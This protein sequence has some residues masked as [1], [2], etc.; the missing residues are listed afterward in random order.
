MGAVVLG[1]GGVMTAVMLSSGNKPATEKAAPSTAPTGPAQD[2][3]ALARAE[4]EKYFKS[5]V[6][7]TNPAPAAAPVTRTVAP[8][9]P[10]RGAPKPKVEPAPMALA[11]PP[12][13]GAGGPAMPTDGSRVTQRFAQDER[14]VMVPQKAAGKPAED[15][16][17]QKF[18]GVFKQ[19]DHATA[20]KSCYERAL[21]RD[22][23][24]KL[25][26]L[27]IN[28]SVGETG[29]AKKVKVVAPSE[30]N[31]VSSCIHDAVRRW[32]FPATNREYEAVFPVILQ[33]KSD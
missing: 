9:A 20:I 19:A 27:D 7:G 29:S 24:L 3:E 21:K 2:P 18:I 28:V 12:I 30:F 25:G 6:G 14:K 13:S 1:L 32:R 17:Y 31:G 23:S 33:G 22:D 15:F 10:K 8:A 11:P 5:M 26:R 16:D 4:A